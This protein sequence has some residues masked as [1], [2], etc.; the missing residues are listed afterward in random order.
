MIVETTETKDNIGGTGTGTVLITYIR[1]ATSSVV[2]CSSQIIYYNILLRKCVLFF[3]TLIR[4]NTERRKGRA[5]FRASLHALT[6]IYPVRHQ[7]TDLE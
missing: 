6:V 2:L 3:L 5:F 7:K 4:L 1:E